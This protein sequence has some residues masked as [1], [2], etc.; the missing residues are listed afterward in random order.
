MS[1]GTMSNVNAN[2]NM[3]ESEVVVL[4]FLSLIGGTVGVHY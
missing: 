3:D 1:G 4:V 2:L